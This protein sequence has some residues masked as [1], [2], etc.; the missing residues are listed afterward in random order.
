MQYNQNIINVFS[1]AEKAGKKAGEAI[2]AHIV[3]LQKEQDTIRIIFAAAPSQT[4]MLNYLSESKRIDWSKIV[5]FHM[6]E[7]IGLPLDASQHFAEYLKSHLFT[8]VPLRSYHVLNTKGAI[9][10]QIEAYSRMLQEEVIDI[11]CLG[12]GE[13]GHIAFNDPPVANFNDPVAVKVVALE[14]AC[15]IQQVNDKCFETLE[16]V[17]KKA[18]T[19]TIP[20]L[21][22]GKKLFCVVLGKT[23]SEAV[24]NTFTMPISEKCPATILRRH[25]DCTF[26]FDE[27]AYEALKDVPNT[28]SKTCLND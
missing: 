21:V 22:A 18:V 6:D 19:L 16:S 14:Q 25:S 26:Y 12:I 27:D 20:T 8:K 5:A 3:Q 28:S 23:K 1:S 2:E 15:R 17:P 7:Y 10:E 9:D 4:S 11:V 13:N 24:K